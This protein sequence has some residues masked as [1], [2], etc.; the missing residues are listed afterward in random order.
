VLID[1]TIQ[2]TVAQG[3]PNGEAQPPAEGYGVV[4]QYNRRHETDF[5]KRPDSA[6]RLE[7]NVGRQRL[8]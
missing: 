3:P 5:Q 6:G 1:W 7:R 8:E 4:K 2:D